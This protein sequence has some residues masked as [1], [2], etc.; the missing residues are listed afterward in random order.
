M[1]QEAAVVLAGHSPRSRPTSSSEAVDYTL[2]QVFQVSAGTARRLEARKAALPVLCLVSAGQIVPAHA[3]APVCA[4]EAAVAV[5]GAHGSLETAVARQS[6]L[7]GAPEATRAVLS[8]AVGPASCP[9][10]ALCPYL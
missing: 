5:V 3:H 1:V 2:R 7:S 4:L 10:P 9:L 8:A 6:L